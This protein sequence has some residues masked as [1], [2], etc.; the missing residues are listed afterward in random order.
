MSILNK[1]IV[2]NKGRVFT[3][4][5][6]HGSYSDFLLELDKVNFNYDEDIVICTGDLVDRGKNSLDC[7]N[8]IYKSWFYTVKG[9]HE[10]FCAEYYVSDN[11]YAHEKFHR[12]HGGKWFYDLPIKVRKHIAHEINNLPIT[13]TL[14]KNNKKYGFVHGDIPQYIRS[15]DELV[16][17]LSS[18]SLGDTVIKSCLQGRSKAKLAINPDSYEQLFNFTDVNKIYL[19]HTVVPN[20]LVRGNMYFIDTGCVFKHGKLT[21]LEV[22]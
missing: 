20:Y 7:F 9:N 19:G 1:E 2:W 15:W 5:D 6:L 11:K 8:L 3:C 17:S 10:S 18:K 21:F 13:I 12:K 22:N 16:S 4:G 14:Y